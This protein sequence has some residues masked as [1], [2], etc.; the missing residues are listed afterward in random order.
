MVSVRRVMGVLV[1]SSVAAWA[2]PACS[3]TT[4]YRVLSFFFD[5]VPEPGSR[6]TVGYESPY[7][8]IQDVQAG[9]AARPALRFNPH[10]PY[11]NN[12]CRACHD[13]TSG[14]GLWRSDREGMCMSCHGQLYARDRYVHGPVA[15]N[16]CLDCHHYHGSPYSHMLLDEA[17]ALCVRCHPR[18]RLVTCDART[19]DETRTCVQCHAAHG[20]NDR[21]FLK[22]GD[23]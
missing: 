20:G 9:P 23:T 1:I 21:F 16:A 4:R 14:G 10:P 5:G 13:V 18:D 15:V 11:R 2:A 22:R 17:A 12:R 8:A 6:P 7:A 19:S 3:G